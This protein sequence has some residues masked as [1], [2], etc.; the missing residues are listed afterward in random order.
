[1]SQKPESVYVMPPEENIYGINKHKEIYLQY[2]PVTG[3]GTA[4][5]SL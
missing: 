1:M 5:H 3:Q 4:G 2:H